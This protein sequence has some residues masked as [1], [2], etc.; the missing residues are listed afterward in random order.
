MRARSGVWQRS[1]WVAAALLLA[2]WPAP[3]AAELPWPTCA[4][5]GCSDPADFSSYLFVAPGT[6][7]DDYSASSGEA[8]KYVPG[9]GMDITGIWEHTTGRP[10]VVI[11]VLDSGNYWDNTDLARKIALNTG[12]LP[13]PAACASHDCNGDGFVSV[14]DFTDAC[15]ADPNGNGHCDGQDLIRFHSDGVDDDANGF[16]DDIAGWDFADDDNDPEDEVRYGHGNGEASDEVAEANNGGGFPGFAP[17]ALYLPLKVADSFIAIDQEFARAV[18][19]AVDRQVGVISEAL[20]TVNSSA[21]GQAAVDYAYRNGI[22]LIASAA[23]EESRHHNYPAAYAHVIWVNSV[24]KGDGTFV[25]EAANGFELLNGCT[26]YGGKAWVAIPSASCSSEATSRAGGLTALLVSHAWNQIDRGLFDPYPGLD[27]PFSAEEVRQLLRLSARDVD[28]SASPGIVMTVLGQVLTGAL[29]APALGLHFGTSHFPSQPGWDQFTGYGRPDGRP[30]LALV[31][32]TTI[33]PEADLSGGPAW[34]D[35]IDPAATPNVALVGS[36]RAVRAGNDFDWTLEIG[37]G[38]QPLTY[39]ELGSGASGGTPLEEAV[40][41]AWSPVATAAAC[42]FDP[43]APMAGDPDAHSVTLRLRVTDSFGNVGEDRRTL[44]IHHDPALRYRRRLGGSGESS[45]ALADVNRDGVLDIVRG[46]GDGSVR[47]IDGASGADLPGFPVWT[48]A[49]SESLAYGYTSG[50]VPIPHEAV[51]ASV[52]A[53]DLDGD[54][55]VEIVAA[56]MQGGLYVWDDHGELRP[57]FPVTTDPA[58]S[59]PANR[60]PLN[61]TDPGIVGAPTLVDLDP[62]GVDPV[63]EIAHSALDGHLYAWR[64][65]G[66]PV[67]GFPVRLA[68]R[69]KVSIDPAT[70][71]ATPLP[72]VEVRNRAAKSLSSPAAGDLDGDGRPELVV[73]TNEEYRGT[74]NAFAIESPLLSTLAMLAGDAFDDLRFDTTGRVYA[75]RA[76]GNDAAGGPFAPGWPVAV[77]VLAPGILPTVGTG[78]PGSP[79][80]VP[81]DGTPRVMLFASTGPPV[82]VNGDG[83]PALGTLGGLPRV[84][85]HDF[86]GGFPN[87]PATA[88]SPDAPFFAAF[89]S[90]AVGDITGDGEPELVAPTGGLRMLLDVVVPAQQGLGDAPAPSGFVGAGIA[91]HHI[92]AWNAGTGALLPAF[93][94]VMDDMQFIG[95]PALADVDG[96]GVAEVL[97]G[98]GA[99]QVRAYRADGT[100]PAGWPKFTHG[101]HIASPTAG[102]VD[103][104]GLTEIV[105]FTR[106][107]ELYVWDTP[108]PATEAALPWTGFGRDRRNTQ[109]LDS[110]VSSRA[111]AVDALA[112]LA[113]V[114]ESLATDLEELAATLPLAQGRRLRRSVAPFLIPRALAAA[115]SDRE[116]R[117]AA[118]LPGIGYGL[119]L[120][121]APIP[122][123]APLEERFRA[124]VRAA[125]ERLIEST[126]CAPATPSTAACENALGW[127]RVLLQFGDWVDAGGDPD[128][129]IRNWAYGIALFDRL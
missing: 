9:S 25:D 123:L 52:A 36:A 74:G 68:D 37:C 119:R 39:T 83:S 75:V 30:L 111:P 95:T 7:P 96:D 54:G 18:V 27:T 58:L 32:P 93:P 99:Y 70:G 38:V 46:S 87:V 109:N 106:E 100:T 19:Y 76:E 88:G 35:T 118:T 115:T 97:N 66:S 110:G 57:G 24:T 92:S 14:D 69:A 79:A 71:K 33:P 116:F 84:L 113:W 51:I 122:E 15:A 48:A 29:S 8:W 85:A 4:A 94:R 61:D 65:D 80:I 1:P 112:G 129:A 102:D 124:A 20:G 62:P 17:S 13:V 50:Q 114:L 105:A 121:T 2:L 49:F 91:H 42:H 55:H 47:A 53:D 59:D 108:A 78:T 107:G 103:G 3:G 128:N 31:T 81:V 67:A 26:N 90:A 101:W 22:P 10:D 60:D 23:D 120:P 63:L 56:G 16:V 6:T 43:S 28:H 77:P 12:E 21:A 44:A 89:G 40:L 126:T 73:A 41:A 5:A 86:P 82:L 11:A 45:P 117:L 104:D 64:A 98:S 72:G 125:L 34:F 127:A